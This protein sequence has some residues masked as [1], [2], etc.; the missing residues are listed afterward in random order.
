MSE[1][2]NSEDLT[3]QANELKRY[4][5]KDELVKIM[6]TTFSLGP[7]YVLLIS[8]LSKTGIRLGELDNLN[9]E[10]ILIDTNQLLVKNKSGERRIPIDKE[11]IEQILSYNRP[12][13]TGPIFVGYKTQKAFVPAT[14]NKMIKQVS[15]ESGIEFKPYK[16]R[17]TCAHNMLAQGVKREEILKNMGWSNESILDRINLVS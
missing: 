10:N 8:I 11:L 16:F 14:F 6:G 13:T 3:S 15:V 5:T 9:L 4:F 17:I 7:S 2:E 1:K 12:R